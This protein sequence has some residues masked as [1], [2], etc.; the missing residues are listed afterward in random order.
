MAD[1]KTK[2]FFT[3]AEL[4]GEVDPE[5]DVEA[6]QLP[7]GPSLAVKTLRHRHLTHRLFSERAIEETLPCELHAGDCHHVISGGDVDSLSFLLWI[8]RK[9]SVPHLLCSTWCISMVDVLELARQH[10]LGKIGKLDFYAGEILPNS[11][12]EE[13]TALGNLC[14]KTGGRI[15]VFRNHSKV[16][17]GIGTDFAFTIESSANINTNPRTEQT[18]I[19]VDESLAAFY[20]E[21]YS[22]IKSFDKSFEK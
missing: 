21:Y 7:S 5:A 22:G 9:Q 11:Y 20:F 16:M 17:A 13:Y 8:L 10:E 4:L 19:T 15:A 6:E 1:I 14:T 3:V 2:R 12:P 18:V